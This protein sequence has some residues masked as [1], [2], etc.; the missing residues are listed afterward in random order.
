M[1]VLVF[2]KKHEQD[3]M[4]TL[5]ETWDCDDSSGVKSI[6]WSFWG[7]G[8]NS[9]HPY[10]AAQP[11]LTPVPWEP[12]HQV[13]SVNASIHLVNRSHIHEGKHSYIYKVK[14]IDTQI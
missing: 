2:K 10:D 12:V 7:P 11:L 13:T 6:C 3:H 1:K 14:K 9:Q 5:Q 4:V 8:F